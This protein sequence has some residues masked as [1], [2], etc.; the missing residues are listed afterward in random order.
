MFF[1]YERELTSRG[2]IL[3]YN[4]LTEI[5]LPKSV[6]NELGNVIVPDGK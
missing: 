1:V 2:T 4:F 6:S 5:T 3:N